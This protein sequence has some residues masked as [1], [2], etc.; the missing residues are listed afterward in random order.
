MKTVYNFDH[1]ENA[2]I[3]QEHLANL[4]DEI[5]YL[6]HLALALSNSLTK[7]LPEE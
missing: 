7:L 1:I 4:Y 2:E 5:R 3:A 6:A